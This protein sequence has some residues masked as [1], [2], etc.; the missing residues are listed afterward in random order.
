MRPLAPT[1]GISRMATIPASM[2]TRPRTTKAARTMTP[3]RLTRL[4][5]GL[6]RAGVR[7]D[8][9]GGPVGHDLR[10]RRRHLAAVEAH[11]D[12]G[13]RAHERRVLDHP[14][15]RLAA[16][17]LEELGVLVDLAPDERAQ[18]RGDVAGKAAAPD[19][20][21]ERLALRL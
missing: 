18:A 11:R 14:V 10:H 20:E 21:P 13:V 12:D 4:L 9:D 16:G 19:D 6:R 5:G 3:R 8:D 15:D 17:V 2:R 1:S 7:D